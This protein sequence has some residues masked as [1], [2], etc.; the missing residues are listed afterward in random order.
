MSFKPVNHLQT[1]VYELLGCT[2]GVSGPRQEAKMPEAQQSW[3]ALCLAS[4]CLHESGGPSVVHSLRERGE[5]QEPIQL[6]GTGKSGAQSTGPDCST[7]YTWGYD[8]A[9][10]GSSNKMVLCG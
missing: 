1:C 3:V 5:Q 4:L 10:P 8:A 9:L 2:V 7:V 6:R